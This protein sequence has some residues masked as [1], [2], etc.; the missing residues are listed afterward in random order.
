MAHITIQQRQ[1]WR[2]LATVVFL[3]SLLASPTTEAQPARP[4]ALAAAV[5]IPGGGGPG[6]P[7]CGTHPAY[8]NPVLLFHFVGTAPLDVPV[9]I[10][11]CPSSSI[12]DPIYVAFDNRGELFVANRHG[13]QGGFGSVARVVFENDGTPV[14]NGVIT[15][16]GLNAPHGLAFSHNGELFAANYL[17]GTISRFRFSP[18]GN[19]IPNGTI[20]VGVGGLI[21]LAFNRKGELFVTA[22]SPTV[23]RFVFNPATGAALPNGTFSVPGSAALHALAFN[24]KGELFIV[25]P[26]TDRVYRFRFDPDG[27]AIENGFFA[28]PR[29]PIGLA[30]SPVGE[31]FVGGHFGGWITRF[32]FDSHGNPVESGSTETPQLGGL[33]IYPSAP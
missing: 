9:T 8:L 17:T 16:P 24:A 7:P 30:F 20:N 32:V 29:G 1:V 14:D 18:R 33:A 13:N 27:T 3:G 11:A 26:Y 4:F 5:G 31:L 19:A 12:N 22:S 23:Y 2:Q 6:S 25:E 15:D 21:G 10:P 28:A